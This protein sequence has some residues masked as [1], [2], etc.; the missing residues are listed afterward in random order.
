MGGMDTIHNIYFSFWIVK[1][2]DRLWIRKEKPWSWSK[3]LLMGVGKSSYDVYNAERVPNV[4][5]W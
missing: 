4:F 1:E 2:I 3:I 5:V